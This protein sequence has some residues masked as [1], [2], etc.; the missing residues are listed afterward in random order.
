MGFLEDKGIDIAAICETWITGHCTPTTAAIKSYGYSIVHNFRA[1]RKGGGTALIFKSS[2]KFAVINYQRIFE[3]FEVIMRTLKTESSR[4]VFVVVYRTGNVTSVFNRELD[5]L[6]SDVSTRADTFILAGDLNLHFENCSGIVKQSLDIFL[7]YGMK[8]LVNEPTHINGSSLD[9]IF[10]HS[11]NK[12]IV[13]LFEINT[14]DTLQSDHF[15]VLCT[16]NISVEKKYFKTMQYRQ[17]KDMD[18]NAFSVALSD[19]LNNFKVSPNFS[20]SIMHL[21]SSVNSTIDNFAPYQSKTISIVDK[22]PWFDSEYR[23]LRK[24]RRQA[25]RIKHR[26]EKNLHLYKNLCIQ[27]SA[28][29]TAKK[30][31][32]FKTIIKK[33]ENK[34][35]TLYQ[36]VNKV[37]DRNQS[38]VLPDYTDNIQQLAAD[39]NEYYI[40]KIEKIREGIPASCH[41]A[42][43]ENQDKGITPLFEFESAS[44]QEIEAIIMESGIKCSPADIL[45]QELYKENITCLLPV[46]TELVNLSLSSGTMDGVKL[47]NIIPLIKDDK[48]DS[49][50]LKNYRPVTNLT[51]LG[52]LIERVVLKRL[53]SHLATNNL[54][55]AD[56]FAYK[57][58]H[59]TETLLIKLTNDLLIAADEKSATV[60]MLLDLSAAF[61]TVDH[62]ILLR[63]LRNEIGVKGCALSWFSSFL[64]GRSQCIR[65][66][67]TTSETVTIRFGV[68]QGS[69][70]GPVL[71]NLYIRSIYCSVKNLGFKILGYADDHQIYQSFNSCNQLN[72]LTIQLRQCFRIIKNWMSLYCLQLNDSKTQIIV[73]GSR[74]VLNNIQLGGINMSPSTTIRFVSCVKNLG[75][76]LDNQLNFQKQ[77]V[78]VKRKCFHTIRNIRKIRFLLDDD[79][80]KLIV[81]SLVISC[82]DYGNGLYYG[83]TEKLFNQLQV[84]QNSAAKVVTK[85]F[86]Y[87]HVG[88]DLNRLHWLTIKKRVIFKIAL[89]TYKSLVGIAPTYLQ[90]MFCYAHFGRHP[91]LII[92]YSQSLHGQRSF[93]NA[94][95]RIYNKL[96]DHIKS[97]A[98]IDVFKKSLKTFLFNLSDSELSTLYRI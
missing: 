49:N 47:G 67:R 38:K 77:I 65:L 83:I 8:K 62:D 6:L 13:S 71:F 35:Y 18:R 33:S 68:P 78:E 27:A 48:L 90:E 32:H 39:F 20:K 95:P 53:E 89:L 3:S 80:C 81:N 44:Q 10:V 87:D 9:Q 31:L 14:T 59:S 24:L 70:L 66:G 15:P 30:K 43:V 28:V 64:K 97:S 42:S 52:K 40:A 54:N 69:V 79:Q 75:F 17:L 7:S 56:Q 12:N 1:N 46:I 91:K 26:S 60:V 88:D 82:L 21:T 50:N 23:N 29:A 2:L 22:A 92:P 58:H 86:K 72:T 5:L 84:I 51:F 34:P 76:L 73:F 94:A 63:I 85:K 37:L 19:I 55:C 25:E 4:V 45:P 36:M 16:F 41:N 93:S 74:N 11:L 98:R 61:D 57:K 96:P